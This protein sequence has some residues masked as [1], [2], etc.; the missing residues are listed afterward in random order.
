ME[1]VNAECRAAAIVG[2]FRLFAAGMR[3][4]SPVLCEI[5]GIFENWRRLFRAQSP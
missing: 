3:F 1:N 2:R 5:L 4:G